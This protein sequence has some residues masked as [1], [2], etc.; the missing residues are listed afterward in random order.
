MINIHI[1]IGKKITISKK[2][3]CWL[4]QN[5][6]CIR[7]LCYK[8]QIILFNKHMLSLFIFCSLIIENITKEI[9]NFA[10]ECKKFWNL[11]HLTW[12]TYID[13]PYFFWCFNLKWIKYVEILH[14]PVMNKAKACCCLLLMIKEWYSSIKHVFVTYSY[15]Y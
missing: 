7:Q 13:L 15:F 2:K 11:Y 9:S 8:K 14:W 6:P 10:F 1:P 12:Y 3:T 5:I 4:N